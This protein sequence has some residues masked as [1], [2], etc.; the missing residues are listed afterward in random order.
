MLPRDRGGAAG[1]IDA[2]I[3]GAFALGLSDA[4]AAA[5]GLAPPPLGPVAETYAQGISQPGPDEALIAAFRRWQM[6]CQHYNA[7]EPAANDD[8]EADMAT[9]AER[10]C[11]EVMAEAEAQIIAAQ[12]CT[13]QGVA[14]QLRI[15]LHYCISQRSDEEALLR[16]DL[17]ALEAQGDKFEP[18]TRLVIAALR[19]LEG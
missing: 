1:Q 2:R 17:A 13:A 4:V 8:D 18:H 14:A 7:L 12:A 6:A 11:M 10:K 16:G 5:D 9:P 3:A 19:S 15:A